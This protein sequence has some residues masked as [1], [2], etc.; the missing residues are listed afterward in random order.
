MGGPEV[1]E[2]K[3]RGGRGVAAVR[4]RRPHR[5]R[6]RGRLRSPP[7]T[8]VTA[9]THHTMKSSTHDQAAGTVK[10]ITGTV[11]EVTGNLIGNP[12]LEA[13]GKVEKAEGRIQ[14]KVGELKQVLGK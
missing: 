3:A 4:R 2:G 14:K 10:K 12:R 7:M 6:P 8:I 5:T 9:K 13:E 11:K 1:T